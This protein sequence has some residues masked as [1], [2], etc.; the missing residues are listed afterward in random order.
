VKEYRK[1]ICH[2]HGISYSWKTATNAAKN[3]ILKVV[4]ENSGST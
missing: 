4:K 1:N 2:K 3:D